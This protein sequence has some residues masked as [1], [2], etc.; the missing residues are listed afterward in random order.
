MTYHNLPIT[1]YQVYYRSNHGHPVIY[2]TNENVRVGT[3]IFHPD[4]ANLPDNRIIRHATHKHI[5]LHFHI[6]RFNDIY[7]ILI[8]EKPLYI[9]FSED[10]KDG[11][12]GTSELEPLGL[13]EVH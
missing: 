4:T 2:C 10:S 7:Q 9:H 1:Y 12:I 11:W 3:L 8:H 13:E 6:S 5:Q